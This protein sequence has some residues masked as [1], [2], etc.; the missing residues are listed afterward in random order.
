MCLFGIAV[1]AVCVIGYR[2][3]NSE[4]GLAPREYVAGTKWTQSLYLCIIFFLK[5][6]SSG[7][8]WLFIV[9]YILR[10]PESKFHLYET[11]ALWS[12]SCVFTRSLLF[13]FI[14]SYD[15]PKIE[16]VRWVQVGCVLANNR[17]K[18][19]NPFIYIPISTNKY[20]GR[21]WWCHSFDANDAFF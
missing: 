5:N 12:S 19:I 10:S 8:L 11:A 21:K 9:Y 20:T 14:F 6:K 15:L 2:Q 3:V 18:Q 13:I 17:I 1:F 16:D 4:I 7:L